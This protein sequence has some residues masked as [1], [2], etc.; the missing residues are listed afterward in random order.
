MAAERFLKFIWKYRLYS[1]KSLKTTCGLELE[2][3]NPGEQNDHAGPDF[4]SARIRL[5]QIIWAGN[6]EIHSRAS[7]WYKHGHHLDPVYNNVILHVVGIY[8]TDITNSLGRRIQTLVPDYPPCLEQRYEILKRSE[9]WLPCGDY[10]KSV[11]AT[12]L[13]RWL[14]SLHAA[15]IAQKSLNMAQILCTSSNNAEEA[16][17][18]ALA[19]GYGIPVNILPFELLVK[20]VPYPK[21]LVHRDNLQDLESILYGHSGLLFPVRNLGPYPSSLWN[22]YQELK[23]SLHEKPLP[24]HLWRFLRLR[25]PSFPTLR[26]SQFAS[27]FHQRSPLAENILGSTSMGELEQLL[28]TGASEYWTTHYLFGKVSPPFPKFPGEQFIST[29]IINVIVPFLNALSKSQCGS[30]AGIQAVKIME[31]LHSENNQIIKMWGIFGIS[32]D[33]AMESQALLQLYNFYCKQK[34][35]LECQVGADIVNTA[36]DEYE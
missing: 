31:K 3:L 10:I 25:P 8:D 11:A 20:G 23:A 15:R 2:I 29:L 27:L 16:L 6:V 12:K 36:I 4:Y 24:R 33:N 18:R 35:C 32:A 22:R 26:I 14:R 30:S 7:D 28:R 19:P 17:Y 9:S 21:L 5:E 1:G 34:R 13:K